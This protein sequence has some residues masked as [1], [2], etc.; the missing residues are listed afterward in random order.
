MKKLT[1]VLLLAFAVIVSW[2]G[3]SAL[4]NPTK[5]GNT[6]P[7]GGI[8][9]SMGGN[10]LLGFAIT[11]PQQMQLTDVG[12]ITGNFSPNVK[13]GIYSNNGGNPYTKLA[14][15][16][17]TS[18]PANTDT[19]IPVTNPV[20]LNPGSYWFMAVYDGSGAALRAAS[21]SAN[22][23]THYTS[24]DFSNTLPAT[25]PSPHSSYTGYQLCYY[26]AEVPE[27]ATLSLLAIGGLVMIK[28]RRK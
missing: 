15:T 9:P 17:A 12:I 11:V 2:P 4:A 25:F 3:G 27:P 14:Q 5:Y 26:L 18:I 6:T 24:F 7:V 1:I 8:F 19:M 28:R 13:V 22:V 21:A 20:S 16:A 23:P 10:A